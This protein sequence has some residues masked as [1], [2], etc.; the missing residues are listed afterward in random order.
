VSNA[1]AADLTIFVGATGSGKTILAKQEIRAKSA[2]CMVWSWKEALDLYAPEFGRQVATLREL[3]ALARAGRPVVYVP[4]RCEHLA[5]D[6]RRRE[7]VLQQFDVF[8]RLALDLG[9]RVVH[10]EEMAIVADSRRAPA[11]WRRIVTEGRA[12]GLVPLAATQRPQLCDATI[13][14]AAT[15]IYCGRLNRGSSQKIMADAMGGLEL[16]RVRG[17][18][19]LQFLVW[20]A[21]VERVELVDVTPPSKKN[22]RPPSSA[23]DHGT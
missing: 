22:R 10:V 5:D 14:D 4:N 23:I 17:L 15:V 7:L 8:C 16:A 18:K 9:D 13:M 12:L 3:T 2:P 6:A 19:P 11:S 1:N 21:G 20:R